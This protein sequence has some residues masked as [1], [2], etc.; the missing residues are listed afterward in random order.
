MK[1]FALIGAAGHIAPRHLQ[2]INDTENR[3]V[4]AYDPFHAVG[5]LDRY[6]PNVA[7]FKEFEKFESFLESNRENID[8][9]SICSPNYLHID[10][11]K[12]ALRYGINAICEKPLALSSKDLDELLEYEKNSRAK[13]YNILQLRVHEAILKLKEK[14][15]PNGYYEIE[16]DY[17][18]S[19]GPWFFQSWQGDENKSGGLATNIGIHFFDMLTWIFGRALKN[20]VHYKSKMTNSG[21][22]ELKRANVNWKLSVDKELL[23]DSHNMIAYRSITVNGE[24]VEFSGGFTDLHTKVYQDIL[25]GKGYGIKD[26]REAIKICEQIRNTKIVKPKRNSLI[27]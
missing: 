4:C 12:C 7:Y 17:I 26:T 23:P 22:L 10:H 24:K 3:V 2:A 8:Y 20:E 1:N 15:S 21:H 27:L 25:A 19:R 5:I 18:T 16:L 9:V 6:N 14:V 13:V 11:I